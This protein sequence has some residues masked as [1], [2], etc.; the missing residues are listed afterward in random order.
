MNTLDQVKA[1][2]IR[3]IEQRVSDKILELSNATL[4]C[5]LIG[6]ASDI[7]E[8]ISISQMGTVYHPTGFH[9]D[10]RLEKTRDLKYFKKNN[11]LS[12][13]VKDDAPTHKLI[14]GD[15]YDALQNLLIEYK[16]MVDVIYIDPPYGKDSMGDFAKTNYENSISRDNLLSMLYPRLWLA[17]KLLSENGVIFCSIDDKNLAY[18]K[19][20]FDEVFEE[21]CY[22]TTL[23][24]ESSVIAG[25]RRVPAMQ[26]S[27]VKTAEYCLVYSKST[28]KKIIKNLKFDYIPGFDTHYNKWVDEENHS[29]V[30]LND[31]IKNNSEISDIFESLN[32]KPNDQNL[33]S[34]VSFN[35]TVRNWLYSKEIANY[36]YRKGS[37]EKE[38]ELTSE[39]PLY[40]LFS[41]NNKWYV[42]TE[43][44]LFNVF[45]Y[46]DRI[47]KCDDYFNSFGERTVRG[48]LW[49]G[50][51]SD[52]GNLD[53]EGGVSFKNGKKPL[54]LIKQLID[55]V[56]NNKDA[57]ILDFFAGSGTTAQAVHELN[58]ND[59]GNRKCLLCQIN[60]ITDEAPNGIA[61]DITA[62]RLENSL[63]ENNPENLDVYDLCSV[64]D[65]ETVPKKTPVDVIDETLY[66]K[67]KFENLQDKIEWICS[68]FPATEQKI[69]ES[70]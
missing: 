40:H 25:P 55:T 20:L 67:D 66:G 45:R 13:H 52:G 51:S 18:L 12:Y 17:K 59:N 24:I 69:K 61:I 33:G 63:K 21:N 44:G 42:K 7:N 29:I 14:I 56:S 46:C 22:V 32:L 47:G 35:K 16:G 4:L 36:L 10:I 1:D 48:N 6:N 30:S 11:E 43:E 58:I 38:N 19:C 5:K 62:K 41:I 64:H 34:L 60:E 31:L 65:S 49:K 9:Y 23:T 8:A 3:E 26:G 54:R 27:I 57:I 50:F 53:K 39:A 68:Y 28:D 15:N 37:Q 2:L 70:K